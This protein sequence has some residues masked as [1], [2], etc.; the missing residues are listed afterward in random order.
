MR[1]SCS[2]SRGRKRCARE[3]GVADELI[4]RCLEKC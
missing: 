4:C 3:K 2:S 1:S